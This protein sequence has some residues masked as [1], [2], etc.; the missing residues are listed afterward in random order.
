MNKAHSG[1]ANVTAN[2]R[3]VPMN[4]ASGSRMRCRRCWTARES[5]CTTVNGLPVGGQP[6][7]DAATRLQQ[8]Q[9]L[10]DQSLISAVEF[11]AKLAEIL[12][13]L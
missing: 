9:Q 1:H 10:R 4:G 6:L 8:L 7:G 13:A 3:E 2:G 5:R 11:G 12:R